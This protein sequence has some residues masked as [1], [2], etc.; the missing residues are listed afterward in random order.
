M[1]ES[2]KCEVCGFWL[3]QPMATGDRVSLGLYDDDRFPGRCLLVWDDHVEHLDELGGDDLLSFTRSIQQVS[4]AIKRATGVGRVN[5]AILGNQEPHLHA[6][7]IPEAATQTSCPI[8]HHGRTQPR[9]AP[10]QSAS[11]EV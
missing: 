2:L 3:W 10:S 4:L 8:R 5:V 9:Q 1:T 7:L 6:H 11:V